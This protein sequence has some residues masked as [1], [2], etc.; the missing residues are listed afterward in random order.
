MP[1]FSFSGNSLGGPGRYEEILMNVGIMCH[2]TESLR[3]NLYKK[4]ERLSQDEFI[5]MAAHQ[6]DS[7]QT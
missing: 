6:S 3:V 7:D 4:P 1:G 5:F 2:K